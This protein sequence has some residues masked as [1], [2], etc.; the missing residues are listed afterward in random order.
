MS[1]AVTNTLVFGEV[2]G[3][4]VDE[5]VMVDG[6]IDYFKVRPVGRLGYLDYVEVDNSFAMERPDWP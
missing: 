2:V 3:V 5:K 4:H 1:R 6:R